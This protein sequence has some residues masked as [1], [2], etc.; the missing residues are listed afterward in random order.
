[1]SPIDITKLSLAQ[2]L[3]Q[4]NTVPE[5]KDSLVSRQTINL[6]TFFKKSKLNANYPIL[7]TITGCVKA[8]RTNNNLQ[9]RRVEKTNQN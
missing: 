2:N 3:T 4:I 8:K 9:F 6:C 1:M 5:I 7:L